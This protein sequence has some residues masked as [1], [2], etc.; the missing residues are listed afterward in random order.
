MDPLKHQ[1]SDPSDTCWDAGFAKKTTKQLSVEAWD[2][3]GLYTWAGE[4]VQA[5]T[6]S[7]ELYQRTS[8]ALDHMALLG[9]LSFVT[10][11]KTFAS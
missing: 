5:G 1:Q 2:F 4:A 11:L 7:L 10:E 9:C 8:P 6:C 3:E